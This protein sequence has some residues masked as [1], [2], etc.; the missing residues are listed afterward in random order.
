MLLFFSDIISADHVTP[1]HTDSP[2]QKKQNREVAFVKFSSH[3][4]AAHAQKAGL[5]P[6]FPGCVKLHS[7]M[8]WANECKD[9][10]DGV[11]HLVTLYLNG[12]DCKRMQH[13]GNMALFEGKLDGVEDEEKLISVVVGLQDTKLMNLA[14]AIRRCVNKY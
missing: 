6:E 8:N 11:N 4:A 12:R 7:A 13:G 2:G 9:V 1:Y 10:C 5:S 3:P 14:A